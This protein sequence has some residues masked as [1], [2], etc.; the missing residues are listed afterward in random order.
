MGSIFANYPDAGKKLQSV[1][2]AY[3]MFLSGLLYEAS[4]DLN[5]AYV[6]YRRALAVMPEA[7]I[8]DRT[9]AAAARLGMRQI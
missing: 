2:N 1:Q 3:L 8:I 6:D 7:E 5:S 9:M 4:N